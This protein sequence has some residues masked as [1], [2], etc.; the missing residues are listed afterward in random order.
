MSP[1]V[2]ADHVAQPNIG[3]HLKNLLKHVE[4]GKQPILSYKMEKP[5]DYTE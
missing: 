2:S 3:F 5:T 4:F 1:F